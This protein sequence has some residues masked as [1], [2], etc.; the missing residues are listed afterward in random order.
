MATKGMIR[1]IR[2]KHGTYMQWFKNPIICR[3][4]IYNEKFVAES[5]H[6]CEDFIERQEEAEITH[7][8][9]Y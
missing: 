2:C 7:Y 6:L 8:D 3:C 5:K 9:H 1:C 4:A